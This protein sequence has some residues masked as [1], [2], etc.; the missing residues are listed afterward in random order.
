MKLRTDGLPRRLLAFFAANPLEELT[1]EQV[2]IKFD[3]HEGT[4]R[5]ALNELGKSGLVE[6]VRVVRLRA[7][8]RS[9]CST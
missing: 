9:G 7:K 8:G 1:P 6:T 5:N 2:A 3:V 4:V